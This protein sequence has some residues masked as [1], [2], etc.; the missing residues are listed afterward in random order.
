[1]L[2]R[3]RIVVVL[4]AYNAALTFDLTKTLYVTRAVL[5]AE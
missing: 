2:N 4:P 5:C 1:M 3:K